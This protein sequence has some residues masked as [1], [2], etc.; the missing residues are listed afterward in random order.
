MNK[1]WLYLGIFL[2]AESKNKL[3]ALADKVLSEIC[4]EQWKKYCH[5][6]TIAFNNES[7]IA[8][9]LH[10]MYEPYF[11]DNIEILATHIGIS[12]D[13]IAV[14]V[15]FK[16]KTANKIPHVTLAT[17]LNGKPVNSNYIT[18]WK[19]LSKPIRIFG[20]IKEQLNLFN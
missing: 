17:P 10:K 4:A 3:S 12:N 8:Y 18:N 20:I 5:H 14:K 16:G 19:K 2:D 1:K 9:N 11:G 7:E 13:A 6:M 15:D